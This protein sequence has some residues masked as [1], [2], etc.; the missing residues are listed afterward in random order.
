MSTT[1]GPEQIDTSK[2]FIGTFGCVELEEF[3]ARICEWLADPKSERGDVE[4]LMIKAYWPDDNKG[5]RLAFDWREFC[6]ND[7]D[8]H[9]FI[10]ACA[11]GWFT[12]LWFPKGAFR[13][14]QAFIDR[15]EIR[16][17]KKLPR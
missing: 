1:S 4:S 11:G 12:H 7:T 5:W 16:W 13:F 17:I 9:W 6:K 3:L 8:I 14:S 15:V 2:K 10:I